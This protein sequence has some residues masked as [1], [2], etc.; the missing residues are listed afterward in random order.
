[1]ANKSKE[2]AFYFQDDWKVSSKLTLN[3]G[4]RYE[5][6][7]PY[8]ERTNQIQF[9]NYTGDTGIAVPINVTDPNDPSVTLAA[10]QAILL[11]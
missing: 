4:I 6:S 11:E 10:V 5:W 2:T 3:F 9:S 1:M 8:S 7:T